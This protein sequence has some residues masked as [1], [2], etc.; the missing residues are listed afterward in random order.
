MGR[1]A[2]GRGVKDSSVWMWS[3][4]QWFS[5]CGPQTSSTSITRELRHAG[6]QAPSKTR[7][8]RNSPFLRVLS[9]KQPPPS[10]WCARRLGNPSLAEVLKGRPRRKGPGLTC[11]RAI[12]LQKQSQLEMNAVLFCTWPGTPMP[13]VTR[14]IQSRNCTLH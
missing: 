6:S 1:M 13:I 3:R 12:L 14:T 8:I 10:F 5:K 4:G 9:I 2:M 11:S 7:H